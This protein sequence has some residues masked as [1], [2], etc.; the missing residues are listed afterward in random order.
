[1]KQTSVVGARARLRRR[2]LRERARRLV[3]EIAI[4]RNHGL[5]AIG[6]F[7]SSLGMWMQTVAMGWLTL[8][9]G[10]TPFDLGL[11]NFA[12]LAPILALGVVGGAVCDRVN[13]RWL[14]IAAQSGAG[15]INLLIAL[16]TLA[17]LMTIPTLIVL[18]FISG[19]ASPFVWPA[20]QAIIRE[21]VGPDELRKAIALN[22][23]RFNLARILGPTIAGG[24]VAVIG[25]AG[26]LIVGSI[27][28]TGVVLTVWLIRYDPP[29][30]G[31]QLKW[32]Q[33][34]NEGLRHAWS[35]RQIR[36]YLL[37]AGGIGLL[38]MP[39][40]AF[41]P[42]YSRDV[43]SAGPEALGLLFTS[44]GIGALLGAITSGIRFVTKRP[45]VTSFAFLVSAGIGLGLYSLAGSL[46][47]ALI[48]LTL[49][50]L[51][52]IGFLATANASVQ[53]LAPH[54]VR[55]RII[56]IWI[57]VN[58]GLMPVGSL[59]FGRLAEISSLQLVSIIGAGGCIIVALIFAL[60]LR[61]SLRREISP[62]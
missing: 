4:N 23:G 32:V 30:L 18:A 55:G 36:A 50:G 12:Q 21:L 22:A 26:C 15:V 14:L 13:K 62:V 8:E 3:A 1:M 6:A 38:A 57:T 42:A 43:L 52:S 17:G 19:L 5:F 51:G 28:L 39:Y 2:T 41:I 48:G 24:L 25:T 29:P 56:G 33:A 45:L 61:S 40:Q 31:P 34:M 54:A 16:L 53:L 7:V 47:V 58:A 37:A 44:V 49:V 46:I 11:I 60:T 27:A 10:G 59:A 35:H 9:L 20:F